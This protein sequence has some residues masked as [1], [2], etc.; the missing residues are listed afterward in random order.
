MSAPASA[1]APALH[2]ISWNVAGLRG[3][4]RRA[5]TALAELLADEQPDVCCLQETKLQAKHVPE[6]TA[7][8]ALDA[9]T[10]HWSC[11]SERLGHAGVLTLCRQPAQSVHLGLGAGAYA[12]AGRA[13]TSSHAGLQVVNVYV[14]NSGDQLKNLTPRLNAWDPALAAHVRQLAQ[15]GPVLLTG[16]LNV[17]PSPLDV[18]DPKRLLRSAGFTEEERH[19]FATH[20]Q[21]QGLVDAFRQLH[22]EAQAYTFFSWRGG[23][24]AKAKGWRLDHMLLTPQLL[25]RLRSCTVLSTV[26]GSDHVPISLRLGPESA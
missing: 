10:A 22:P 20:L 7:S 15:A 19:S 5:P 8:L 26:P 18:Y 14:P 13:I 17:A 23:M 11:S 25:P 4:L 2:L 16:D 9:Y 3:L 12:N 24:R 1:G 21:G 6:V